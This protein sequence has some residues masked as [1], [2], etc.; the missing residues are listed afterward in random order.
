LSNSDGCDSAGLRYRD[1]QISVESFFEQILGNL[2]SFSTACISSNDRDLVVSDARQQLLSM[3]IYWKRLSEFA[4]F[5]AFK[6]HYWLSKK[7]NYPI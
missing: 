3:L 2:S 5:F 6:L 1:Y 4:D 7:L